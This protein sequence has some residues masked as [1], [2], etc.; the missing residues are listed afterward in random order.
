MTPRV[1]FVLL[2][3]LA[4]CG[5]DGPSGPLGEFYADYAVVVCDHAE[6]C[7]DAAKLPFDRA[8]CVESVRS[9][10]T[11]ALLV[12][13]PHQQFDEAAAKKCLS[14]T[15]ARLKTCESAEPP[16]CDVLKGTLDVGDECTDNDECRSPARGEVFCDSETDD[17]PEFCTATG[18]AKEGEPC[19]ATCEE[20]GENC[21]ARAE[22]GQFG[23]ICYREDDLQC[24]PA[25][26]TC[27]PLLALGTPCDGIDQCERGTWCNFTACMPRLDLGEPCGGFGTCVE[28]AYCAEDGTC[29]KRKDHGEPCIDD[30][31]CKET[32]CSVDGVCASDWYGET[33]E[34]T[35]VGMLAC[36]REP[37]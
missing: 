6:P 23:G 35:F 18:P 10:G 9:L 11:L 4:A 21:F 26:S 14:Q 36:R 19:V 15:P 20:P 30:S 29:A 27:Q 17:G 5:G 34:D 28:D 16:S 2:V 1:R 31:E 32:V 7:C 13:S 37:I 8:A 24:E 12:S 33:F 3:L 25:T 22:A